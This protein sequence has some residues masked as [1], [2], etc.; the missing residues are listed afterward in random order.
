MGCDEPGDKN[1]VQP[2]DEF[3]FGCA[4][5]ESEQGANN[6]RCIGVRTRDDVAVVAR[7]A[8][9][10]RVRDILELGRADTRMQFDDRCFQNSTPC[11]LVAQM[12]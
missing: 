11:L 7:P 9:V 1:L 6:V 4:G 5:I 10:V 2:W 12:E 8:H 3:V